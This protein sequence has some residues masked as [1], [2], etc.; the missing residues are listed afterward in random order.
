MHPSLWGLA[1][2]NRAKDLKSDPDRLFSPLEFDWT[3]QLHQPA[4]LLAYEYWRSRCAGRAMPSRADLDPVTM[5]KFTSHVGL[6]EIR[7]AEGQGITY[8]IRRAGTKWEEVFG[9]MTGRFLHE[10]LSLEFEARWREVFDAVREAK[11]PV[12]VT[13]GIHFQRK[14]WLE[15]EMFVAPLGEN[16]KVTMLF[17]TFVASNK[18]QL[19]PNGL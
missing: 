16:N 1:M 12:R 15:T 9:V 10:F 19:S 4:T 18:R 11:A 14:T 17:M 5:R 13:T 2:T 6:I 8:F 7:E 3:V